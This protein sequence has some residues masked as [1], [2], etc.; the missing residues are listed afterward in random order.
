MNDA[1]IDIMAPPKELPKAGR[2]ANPVKRLVIW[3]LLN[4][5]MAA[6]LIVGTYHNVEWAMNVV[7]FAIWVN[8]IIWMLIL[9]GGRKSWKSNR[10]KGM[11]VGPWV[12]GAYG[13]FFAGVLASAG[14]FGYAAMEITTLILQNTIHFS[15]EIMDI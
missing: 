2:V 15:D 6:F 13:I 5:T 12:N 10:D 1:K 8:F 11:S 3:C 7:K 14:F 4:G 9:F